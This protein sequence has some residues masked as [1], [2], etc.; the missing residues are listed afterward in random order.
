MKNKSSLK[1]KLGYTITELVVVITIIGIL[2]GA[3]AVYMNGSTAAARTNAMAKNADQL[4]TAVTNLTGAGAIWS[5][6]AYSVTNGSNTTPASIAMPAVATPAAVASLAGDL[7]SGNITCY[8]H[9]PTLSKA[10]TAASYTYTINTVG[11]MPVPSF[12]V[13][14][15]ATQP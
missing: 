10:L 15:G 1:S 4:N 7:L 3:V 5:S 6:G 2:I 14:S 9:T 12:S 11:G 13:V 8:G